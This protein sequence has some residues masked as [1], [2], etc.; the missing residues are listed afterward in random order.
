MI[1]TL[2]DFDRQNRRMIYPR[3]A[4]FPHGLRG[5]KIRKNGE[6]IPKEEEVGGSRPFILQGNRNRSRNCQK[7][8][9]RKNCESKANAGRELIQSLTKLR[10]TKKGI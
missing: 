3:P 10:K 7:P 6:A 9:T 5:R 4:N 8:S 2:A 1:A